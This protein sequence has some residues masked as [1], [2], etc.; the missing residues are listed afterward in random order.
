[1][2]DPVGNTESATD[3]YVTMTVGGQTFGVP[4][5]NVRDVLSP[6]C[7]TRIPLAP[8]EIAGSL[9]L[10]GRIVTAID[11]RRRLNLPSDGF[12][13]RAMAVVVE[14]DDEPFSL[15]VD[16]VGEVLSL[17]AHRRE[18]VPAT[19]DAQ[20]REVSQGIYR[21]DEGLLLVLSV[22]SVLGAIGAVT[23]H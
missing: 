20:W 16:E 18:A 5:L 13:E 2:N 21:L 22:A 19:L 14:H 1:M 12:A 6:Q 7:I 10:R 4:V 3:D 17:P 8:A 15:L 9:N 23:V 11:M